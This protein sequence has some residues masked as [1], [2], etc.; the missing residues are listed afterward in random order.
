MKYEKIKYLP[1]KQFKNVTGIERETFKIMVEILNTAYIKVHEKGG[2]PRN[3][4]IE[5]MLLATLEYLYEHRTQECIGA[6]FGLRRQNMNLVIKWVETELIKS[7]KFNL[8]GKATLVDVTEEKTI[9][10][11]TTETPIQRPKQNQKKYYSGKKTAHAES[12]SSN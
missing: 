6:S 1:D 3:L 11:D 8:P 10:V 2:R 9:I 7:G 4:G 12:T 5:D